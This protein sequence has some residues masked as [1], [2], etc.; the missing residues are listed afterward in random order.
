MI[1]SVSV[2]DAYI[3]NTGME[4]CH[5]CPTNIG[6]RVASIK[7]ICSVEGDPLTSD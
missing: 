2:V 5:G 7:I 4:L 6:N 3:A 1:Y